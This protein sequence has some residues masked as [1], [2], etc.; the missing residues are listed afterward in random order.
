MMRIAGAT[1]VALTS[2]SL[3]APQPAA[4]QYTNPSTFRQ[5][6]NPMSNYLDVVL[7]QRMQSR[8]LRERFL[9]GQRAGG[10]NAAPAAP[11]SPISATDF[12]ATGTRLLPA[13][14][15]ATTPDLTAEQKD[16]LRELSL[17]ALT[18][19]EEQARKNNVAYALTFLIGVS[20][21]VVNERELPDAD[22]EQLARE[23][24]DVLASS[25]EFRRSSPRQKQ[26]LYEAAVITGGMI[27]VIYQI[28]VDEGNNELKAQAQDMAQG[29]ITQLLGERAQ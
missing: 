9:E 10:R 23:L 21:Q 4:A 29:V 25:P 22:A 28:G 17:Q 20:M 5:W 7:Q 6:N 14:L 15:A 24:N 13:T 16:Q 8:R 18:A 3:A 27:G 1:L 26:L 2:L 11:R 19:F 12:R